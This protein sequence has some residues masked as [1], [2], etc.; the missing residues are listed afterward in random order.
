MTFALLAALIWL[1]GCAGVNIQSD[2]QQTL[3]QGDCTAAQALIE[4]SH[5]HYGNN[6][7]LLYLLDAAMVSLQCRDYPLAQ[8]RLHAA[9]DLAEKLWTESITRHAV[10]MVT[11]E[12]SLKYAGEDYERVMIHIVSAIGYLQTGQLDEALV[13]VRRLDTLLNRYAAEYSEDQF[14]KINAFAR[15]LSGMIR[16]ADAEFDE[17]FIDYFK[18][19]EAY[20]NHQQ[21][22]G[23]DVP[24]I[25]AQDLWRL[26]SKVGRSPDAQRLI[27]E[28]PHFPEHSS[29]AGPETG[30]LVLV[31]FGGQGPQKVQDTVIVPS[32]RGP[33]SVA[34]PRVA[35]GPMPCSA[36]RLQLI[37]AG[38]APATQLSLV[39]DIHA[40]AVKSL[41]DKK[42]RI[43]AKALARAVAKQMVIHGIASTQQNARDQQ[44]VS[45]LLNL[46]NVLVLE[47]ADLR[48]WRTLPGHIMMAR[49]FLKPG[50]YSGQ[51][52]WCQ[53][54]SFDLGTVTITAGETRF[55]FLDSRYANPL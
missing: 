34:F 51:V 31:V 46:L 45:T 20:Q 8:E 27:G 28:A 16:E 33:I 44:A 41:Y 22:Y 23:V 32:S 39:S 1:S 50:T 14:Y 7:E 36:G 3:V 53:S 52:L 19:A 43:V 24:D 15:Y 4:D 10:S 40:I 6:A 11:S 49:I 54:H 55:L 25:L 17:A 2:L 42:G 38:A 18:A 30:K 29:E 37:G 47:K 21:V 13:E 9:E 48:S 5:D 35:A 26:A 12:Y